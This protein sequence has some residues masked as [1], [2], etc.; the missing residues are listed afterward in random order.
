MLEGWLGGAIHDDGK[1]T[2]TAVHVP[3]GLAIM[4]IATSLP[5]RTAMLKR[6]E[7]DVRDERAVADAYPNSPLGK[8]TRTS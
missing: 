1:D 5:T 8:L 3:L 2:L 4:A 7:P 6:H